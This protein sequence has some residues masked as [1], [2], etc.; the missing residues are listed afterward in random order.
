[1]GKLTGGVW[2]NYADGEQVGYV[3]KVSH[4]GLVWKTWEVNVQIGTGDLAALQVP[5]EF[6]VQPDLS[7][8]LKDLLGKKVTVQYRQWLIVPYSIGDADR[9]IVSISPRE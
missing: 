9:E 7:G 6:C 1:M 5:M 2:S 3:T 8:Q 4:R